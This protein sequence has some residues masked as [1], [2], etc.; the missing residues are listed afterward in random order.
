MPRYESDRA[1]RTARTTL[2]LHRQGDEQRAADRKLVE[3]REVLE[4]RDV[5][6]RGHAVDLEV[7]RPAIVDRGGV[8]AEGGDHSLL[9]QQLRRVDTIGGERQLRRVAGRRIS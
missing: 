4:S 3:V 6:R 9:D 5:A 7:S 2:D 1:K 8:D